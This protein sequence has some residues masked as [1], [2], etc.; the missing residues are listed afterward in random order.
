M[1]QKLCG[2]GIR[3]F[4]SKLGGCIF[5]IDGDV[6][7]F[8]RTNEEGTSGFDLFG[9]F[10]HNRTSWMP[11]TLEASDKMQI[12]F[13]YP[14]P[15]YVNYKSGAVYVTRNVERQYKL[16]YNSRVTTISDRWE[17]E[18][19]ELGIPVDMGGLCDN[20]HFVARLFDRFFFTY[21]Q[22]VHLVRNNNR[23]G[24]AISR[25]VYIGR[26]LQADYLVICYKDKVVGVVDGNEAVLFK[27][28][29][30]IADMFPNAR[31]VEAT[32]Y[33]TVRNYWD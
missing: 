13:T 30:Y 2:M 7:Q 6:F 8:A 1:I 19:S 29:D 33:A 4:N 17:A 31:I 16:A 28:A 32:K 18:R 3:D 21:E 15:G 5:R 24:A 11:A 26:S 10:I 25:Y 23:L 9:A 27:E 20:A 14:T 22:A 12:D